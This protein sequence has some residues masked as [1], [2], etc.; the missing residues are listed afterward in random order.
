[1][2]PWLVYWPRAVSRKNTGIP[3]ANRKI[4]YGMKKA[5]GWSKDVNP[6]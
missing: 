3:H 2:P 4:R 5:P 6:F 1:M